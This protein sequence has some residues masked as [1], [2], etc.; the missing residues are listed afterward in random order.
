MNT[1][2]K[3]QRPDGVWVVNAPG[4]KTASAVYEALVEAAEKRGEPLCV[5]VYVAGAVDWSLRITV[6]TTLDSAPVS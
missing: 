6:P 3:Y 2:G 1:I 5:E 4:W